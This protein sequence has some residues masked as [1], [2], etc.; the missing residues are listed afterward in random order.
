MLRGLRSIIPAA[1]EAT[2]LRPHTLVKQK[3]MLPMGSDGKKIIDWSLN[4]A[5]QTESTTVTLHFDESKTKD[6]ENHLESKKDKVAAL[7]DSR[8]MGQ[9]H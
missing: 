8:R 5:S 6:L 3:P 4:I 1:G 2:R 9:P 7:R